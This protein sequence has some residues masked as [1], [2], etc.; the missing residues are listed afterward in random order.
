MKRYRIKKIEL[1]G[2]RV[3]YEVQKRILGCLWWRTMSDGLW[4]AYFDSFDDA[5]AFVQRLLFKPKTTIVK[6][7]D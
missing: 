1:Y 6:D 5:A 4:Y 7:Y 2:G 3:K